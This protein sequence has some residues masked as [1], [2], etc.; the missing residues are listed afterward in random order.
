MRRAIAPVLEGATIARAE[1]VDPGSR[2]RSSRARR[3]RARRRARRGG[4]PPRQ[5]PPRAPRE[6]T[7]ARRPPAHDRLAAPRTRGRA[8]RRRLSA[9]DPR[10]QHGY[11]LAYR[12][13]RR[14]GTWELLDEDHLA[15]YLAARLGPEPLEPSFTAARLARLAAGRRAPVKSFLLDQRRIAGIGNIYADEAL[16]RARI[17]PRRPAGELTRTSSRDCTARSGPRSA[18]ESSCGARRSATTSRQTAARRHAARVPRVRPG[19]RAVR[20]LWQADR[21]DRGRRPRHVVLPALPAALTARAPRTLETW[22]RRRSPRPSCSG[23]SLSARPT[24]CSTSTRSRTAARRRR[25]R[26][27]AHEEPLR[28]PARAFSH[29]ELAIHRGRESSG[30]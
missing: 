30:P 14:F 10:A 9:R 15:P 1:I 7:H 21:A 2:G 17:H 19:G 3:R 24:G 25:E 16:W 22:P 23:R 8:P 13:V 12:D 6:R 20:P 18:E 26:C 28:R 29:V 4:R 5:V 11:R 27:P